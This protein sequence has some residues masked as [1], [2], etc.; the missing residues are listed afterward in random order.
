MKK[1]YFKASKLIK[2]ALACAML[3]GICI[4]INAFAS[5]FETTVQFDDVEAPVV[6]SV[7]VD[8]ASETLHAGDSVHFVVKAED[9]SGMFQSDGTL[10]LCSPINGV[11]DIEVSLS[12][13][14]STSCFEGE[15]VIAEDTYPSEW[16]VGNIDIRDASGRYNWGDQ[17]LNYVNERDCY[18]LVEK[19]GSVDI[20][21]YDIE[22]VV[23]YIDKDYEIQSIPLSDGTILNVPRR[24][25]L[26]ELKIDLPKDIPYCLDGAI[27]Q[28]WTDQ[29]GETIDG[30]TM[31][32]DQD[33]ANYYAG[34]D[35]EIALFDYRYPD[36]NQLE[37]INRRAIF[38]EKGTTYAEL[39]DQINNFLPNDMYANAVFTGWAY[40]NGYYED[41]EETVYWSNEYCPIL[42]AYFDGKI[43]AVMEQSYYDENGRYVTENIDRVLDEGTTY[44]EWEQIEVEQELPSIFNGLRYTGWN[45]NFEY[46]INPE[47]VI[48]G[49]YITKTKTATYENCMVTF[50]VDDDYKFIFTDEVIR[51][52]S[53][54]IETRAT[55]LSTYD[56]W[57]VD[58]DYFYAMTAEVGDTI[59]VIQPENY[60]NVK[61]CNYNTAFILSSGV[62][63]DRGEIVEPGTQVTIDRHTEFLGIG[64]KNT[65]KPE[66]SSKLSEA[67]ITKVLDSIS[68][69][70]SGAEIQ[71]EMDDAFILPAEI[72]KA[73]AEKGVDLLVNMENY[74]WLIDGDTIENVSDDVN[75]KMTLNTNNV[76]SDLIEEVADGN[77]VM[78]FA[79]E[80]DGEFGFD[81]W[82]TLDVGEENAG[83]NGDLYYFNGEEL[84]F[85][86]SNIV[87][88]D[89]MISFKFTH[90]SD[91]VVVL[92]EQKAATTTELEKM[93]EKAQSYLEGNYTLESKDVLQNAINNAQLIMEKEDVT[94]EEVREAIEKLS[95]AISKLVVEA[96]IDKDAL[97]HE[98][99]LA[100]EMIDHIEDYVP[101]SVTGLSDKLEVAQQV[102]DDETAVQ[103]EVDA[104][105]KTIREARLNARTRADISALRD[106]INYVNKL[107]LNV[108]E[109]NDVRVLKQLLNEGIELVNNPEVTQS[110]VDTQVQKIQTMIKKMQ[111]AY[112][113][114]ENENSSNDQ[115]SSESPETAVYGIAGF[116]LI[117]ILSAMA[118]LT[119]MNRRKAN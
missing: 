36:V 115:K 118:G 70:E 111:S 58:A 74:E 35:K 37:Q 40:D 102:Y 59:T 4:P 44:G 21:T 27:F 117:L 78:Q 86:D 81:A 112:D 82:L 108:Y 98:I 105:T 99:M 8:K 88:K 93:I 34:Y 1:C 61:F 52:G 114:E 113:S 45:V 73:A 6:T 69:S 71:V 22:P 60:D 16:Y 95:D 10:S 109:L 24:S 25:T 17:H 57:Q 91:Y 42:N 56:P 26:S 53:R 103:E 12:Y 9:D 7:E 79:L 51:P 20:P 29:S 11:A 31:I 18:F 49:N 66:D 83:K 68:S 14:D 46:Y 107:N 39:W 19:D 97:A 65:S 15:F 85:Q 2:G 80:H 13:V 72:L 33:S 106:L 62:I 63:W 30:N 5:D 3:I 77:T 94:T 50:A 116:A 92:K 43:V 76:P 28:S 75:F 67:E 110:D 119:I 23:K 96:S 48:T 104:A 32:I 38:V 47:N 100:Q 84:L 41:L 64:D 89:G 87:E 101:S 54:G 55:G 90:A